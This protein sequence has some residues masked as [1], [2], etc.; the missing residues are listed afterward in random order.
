LSGIKLQRV[1]IIGAGLIGEKRAAHLKG[2][3]L[4]AVADRDQG[5]ALKLASTH[6]AK[7]EDQWENLVRR[8]DIDIVIVA[9]SN[10]AIAECATAALKS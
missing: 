7:T 9:T 5:R 6:G 2:A 4:V 3:R 8:P 1:G 10:D